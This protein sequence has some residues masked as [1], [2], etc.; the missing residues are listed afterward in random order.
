MCGAVFFYFMQV[1]LLM[2]GPSGN[3]LNWLGV[4]MFRAQDT[5]GGVCLA[6]LDAY[7]K[8]ALSLAVPALFFCQLLLTMLIH[9][10]CFKQ[11]THV[12]V[13]SAHIPAGGFRLAR[14]WRAICS[15]V[16]AFSFVSYL[17]T[18]VSL[19]LLSYIQVA[20]TTFHF[21]QCI[22]LDNG[23][24]VIFSAPAISCLDD[25]YQRWRIAAICLILVDV[26]GVPI[27]VTAFLLARKSSL[28]SW[29]FRSVWGILFES[30]S[31]RVPWWQTIILCRRMAFVAID[32]GLF[33]HP[34]AKAMAFSLLN[35]GALLGH[36][37][38][39]PYRRPDLNQHETISLLMLLIL[40]IVLAGSPPPYA[41]GEQV[42]ITLVVILPIVLVAFRCLRPRAPDARTSLTAGTTTRVGQ[43]GGLEKWPSSSNAGDSDCGQGTLLRPL[44]T[45]AGHGILRL[46]ADEPGLTM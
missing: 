13:G 11:C 31:E 10:I 42:V 36:H 30:F 16:A 34:S 41:T 39:H 45:P 32:A 44:L 29:K 15:T 26:A 17:R 1:A 18:S 21:L 24:A 8:I 2:V 37:I 28:G 35:L 7:Q 19:V 38:V 20:N 40:S 5:F 43:A 3:W 33:L 22:H 25:T 6:P 27:A 12:T 9:F 46:D 14:C 4:L 23:A